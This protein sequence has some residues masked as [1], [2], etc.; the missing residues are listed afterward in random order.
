MRFGGNPTVREGAEISDLK[1]EISKGTLP[2]GQV[3]AMRLGENFF[4]EELA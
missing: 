4:R 2:Y 3:S 1:F